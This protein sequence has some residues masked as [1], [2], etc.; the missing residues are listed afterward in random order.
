MYFVKGLIEFHQLIRKHPYLFVL[1]TN[2][3]LKFVGPPLRYPPGFL[4]PAAYGG[5]SSLGSSL[6]NRDLSSLAALQGQ[7]AQEQWH[8]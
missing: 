1:K 6:L 4:G 2:H 3:N 8:R 7:S 5:L